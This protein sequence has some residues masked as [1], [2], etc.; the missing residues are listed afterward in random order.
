M[1]RI[2][3]LCLFWLALAAGS[4]ARAGEPPVAM[5]KL[6]DE[7]VWVPGQ[8]S[9]AAEF[10]RW[11]WLNFGAPIAPEELAMA[12]L[13][14]GTATTFSRSREA[15]SAPIST[16]D[17]DRLRAFALGR[18]LFRVRWS[19]RS[20]VQDGFD[21]LGP[22]FNRNSCSGC[23]LKDGRGQPPATVDKP[24]ESMLVRLSVPGKS[25]HGG[26]LPHPVYG[27]QLQDKGIVGVP[28]EGRVTIEYREITGSFADGEPFSLRQPVYAFGDLQH[29][30][31]GAD[32]LVSPRV[33]PAIYGLGLLEAVEQATIEANADPDDAD[34][35]GISGRV[36]R[37]WDPVSGQQ[38]IGRFGWKA[39]TPNLYTQ[40]AAAAHGDMG[41]T[42]SVFP[43]ENCPAAQAACAETHITDAPELDDARLA[44]LVLYTRSLGVPAKRDV[45]DP[46]THRGAEIFDDIGCAACH[47]PT[48]STGS[49]PALPELTNITIQPYTNL[50]L[51]DMGEGLADGRPDYAASGRE[52]RTPPLWGIGLVHRVNMHNN[53][54][55]DGRARGLMEAVL[56]HGGEAQ[57]ARDTVIELS[58]SDRDALLAFLASL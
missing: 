24:M 5:L 12:G 45:H 23:H 50:L 27:G 42:T 20:T 38:A 51:H 34:S 13:S 30:P 36:N 22:T 55:H 44:T 17:Q 18:K 29:G 41:L 6:T 37:V 49:D 39:N 56:W 40:V 43:Q 3:T 14:A 4:V 35:D 33:A 21:G 47:T 32:V 8:G 28:R 15:F 9:Y 11:A 53:F 25:A 54:L 16:L 10:N 19:G 52:W 31:V 1:L 7:D 58:S 26:P 57:V 48:L 46:A 2:F